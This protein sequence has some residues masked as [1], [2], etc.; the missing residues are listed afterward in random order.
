MARRQISLLCNQVF[1][2]K[3]HVD[4]RHF[5][6]HHKIEKN[7][8]KFVMFS[9]MNIQPKFGYKLFFT[10]VEFSNILLHFWLPT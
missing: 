3:L 9:H 4:H 6:L 1:S 8:I 2:L 10:K 5:G 7:K